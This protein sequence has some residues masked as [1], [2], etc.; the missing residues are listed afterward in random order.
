[1]ERGTRLHSL[2][3]DYLNDKTTE[4]ACHYDLRRIA[5]ELHD[6]RNKG[7]KAE[8]TF[9]VDADWAPVEDQGKAK[10]KAIVDVHWVENDVLHVRDFKSGREYPTH[11]SQLELYAVLGLLKYPHVERCESAAVYIDGGY[12]GQDG[13]IIRGMLPHLVDKWTQ[14]IIK[15]EAD[16]DFIA[17]PGS[18]CRWCSF[19]ASRGGPCGE[20]AKAGL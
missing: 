5:R 16:N 18:S 12:Q 3:E 13:S 11:R 7:A 2:C 1:M 15:I 4:V 9:L 6:M 20:S 10:M 17:N 14:K 8:A 19:A